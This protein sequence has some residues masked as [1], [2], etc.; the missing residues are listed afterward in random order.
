MNNLL[1]DFF[2]FSYW[3]LISH[4]RDIKHKIDT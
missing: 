3:K 1:V 2:P 4:K